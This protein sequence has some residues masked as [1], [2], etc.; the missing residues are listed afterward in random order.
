MEI[1]E[2]W[3][4]VVAEALASIGKEGNLKDIYDTVKDHQ[5]TAT[6]PTWR[7][8]I[9]RTLQQYSIFYQNEKGSG[10]WLLKEEIPLQKFDPVTNPN[11]RHEDI[12]GMLL[13]LGKLY[14][15]DTFIPVYDS[16]KMFFNKK[17][18]EIASIRYCPNFSH[19][20]IVKTASLIDVIWFNGDTDALVPKMAFE[21]EH[22]TDITK[23]LAR[24]HELYQSGQRVNLFVLIPAK[25]ET[26][27]N[28]EIQRPLFSEIRDICKVKTYQPLIDLYTTAIEHYDKYDSFFDE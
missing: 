10:V 28:K 4:D 1:K 13:E 7:D 18:E 22:S 19:E 14:G 16:Q 25:K 27:F 17:L 21:V 11:P 26:K 23:G 15:Y 12:Q 24:L 8:T 3:K 6:N 20:K 5:K 2:T 9:R